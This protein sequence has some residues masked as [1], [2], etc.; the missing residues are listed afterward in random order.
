VKD[1][2][3]SDTGGHYSNGERIADGWAEVYECDGE[4]ALTVVRKFPGSIRSSEA[5]LS[6]EQAKQLRKYLKKLIDKA[7]K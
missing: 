7:S 2:K 3:L 1:L 6:V 5:Y 4:I